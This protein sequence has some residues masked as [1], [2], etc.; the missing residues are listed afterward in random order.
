MHEIVHTLDHCGYH[1]DFI[2]WKISLKK[3]VPLIKLIIF[4][5]V[6]WGRWVWSSSNMAFRFEYYFF[7]EY[8]VFLKH[9]EFPIRNG[10]N[11][12]YTRE[13]KLKINGRIFYFRGSEYQQPHVR[14][15][16][17]LHGHRAGLDQVHHQPLRVGGPGAQ[18]KGDLKET[19]RI[20]IS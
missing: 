20:S 11:V 10:N 18:F 14:G 19:K 12:N 17:R 13:K 1:F 5:A 6:P 8:L 3:N 4:S 2:I 16:P 7:L 9:H 15:V